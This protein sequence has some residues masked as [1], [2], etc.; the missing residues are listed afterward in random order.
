MARQIAERFRPE[1]I[2]LFGSYAYGT[3]H[4]ESDVDLLVIMPTRNAI[5][6]AI[7]ISLAFERLFSVDVH[8]RTPYQ[9]K[10][11][12][13][14]GDCDWFLREVMEK[15]KVLYEAPHHSVGGEGR[16]R[17]GRSRRTGRAQTASSKRGV[18]PLP[19]GR[20]EVFQSPSPG[21]RR[22]RAKDA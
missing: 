13:K 18:L 22:R 8:V 2:I 14:E 7:R 4:N 20:G 10:Q 9:I 19:A 6:Q 12:L 21:T 15:G 5:D 16:R 17:R 1:K 3:P 11:A